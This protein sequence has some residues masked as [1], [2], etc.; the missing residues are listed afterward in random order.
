[1]S[2]SLVNLPQGQ[3]LIQVMQLCKEIAGAPFYHKLGPGGV[4]AIYLTAKE[5]NLPFMFCLNGGLHNVQGKVT[6]AA[7]TMA[8]MILNAGHNYQVLETNEKLCKIK[9]SRSDRKAP[10]NEYTHTYT[11]DDAKVA[12]YL[13]RLDP[14]SGKMVDVKDNWIKQPKAMLYSRCMSAGSK[15]FMPDVMMN[16]YAIG[17][18]PG[19]E[20]IQTID[21]EAFEVAPSTHEN[22]QKSIENTPNN[23]QKCEKPAKNLE[24]PVGFADFEQ[25]LLAMDHVPKYIEKVMNASGNTQEQ[26]ILRAM[27]NPEGFEEQFNKWLPNIMMQDSKDN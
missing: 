6:M 27:L 22:N 12:G 13:G 16:V 9:F 11:L 24:K 25:K 2:K 5:L 10:H 17:E 26:V 15:L 21:S 19:D 18:I 20:A 3:E 14:V 7:T 8:S 4:L 23:D 1:M